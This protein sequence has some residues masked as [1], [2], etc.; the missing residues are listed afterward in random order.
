MSSIA[1]IFIV[2]NLLLAALCLGWVSNYMSADSDWQDK[3]EKLE[4][5]MAQK[6]ADL[7]EQLSAAHTAGNSEKD[8][9]SRFLSERD[10]AKAQTDTLTT[11]LASATETN[12]G[13]QESFNG[14]NQTMQEVMSSKDAAIAKAEQAMADL[15]E[16]K[17]ARREAEAAAKDAGDAQRDAEEALANAERTIAQLNTEK[18][19][20]TKELAHANTTLEV[21]AAQTGIDLASVAA[22]PNIDG[23]VVS[24]SMAVEP[25]LVG[26]NRGRADGVRRGHTF[27]IYHGA[28][29]KGTAKV[30]TVEDNMCFAV[31]QR[32]YQDRMPVTGDSVATRL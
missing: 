20:L 3:H 31:I 27:S 17:D 8:R 10:N 30:E 12:D 22:L 32:T 6:V 5:E 14:M 16:A 9:A 25:G 1:R 28:Q 19:S 11:Q 21:V 29:F 2:L 15:N 24:V 26:I 4:A 23:A 7:D 18:T 13:L